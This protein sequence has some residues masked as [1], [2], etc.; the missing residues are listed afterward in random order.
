MLQPDNGNT[1]SHFFTLAPLSSLSQGLPSLQNS[2]GRELLGVTHVAS[3]KHFNRGSEM[4]LCP[5]LN[6]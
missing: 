4:S 2:Q 3:L 5:A 6:N 1:K